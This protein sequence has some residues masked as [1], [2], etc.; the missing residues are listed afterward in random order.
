MA[1]RAA[2]SLQIAESSQC[3][4]QCHFV[5]QATA[6]ALANGEQTF[7]GLTTEIVQQTRFRGGLG[8]SFP[9]TKGSQIHWVIGCGERIDS[10][11]LRRAAAAASKLVPADTEWALHGVKTLDVETMVGAVTEGVILGSY[12]F[13]I[14]DAKRQPCGTCQLL[15]PAAQH[16]Q[17]KAV[18][19]KA[20][21]ICEGT[22]LT[23]DLVKHSGA[24]TRARGTRCCCP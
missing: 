17:A 4:I 3:A 16:E 15:L 1:D 23:R 24:A 2:A 13:R 7:S 21:A 5:D 18:L 9:V 14:S 8:Q 6:R 20:T 12:R 22:L 19:Q 10:S 11:S